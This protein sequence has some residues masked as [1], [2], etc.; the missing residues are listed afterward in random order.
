MCAQSVNGEAQNQ[1]CFVCILVHF[2]VALA[3]AAAIKYN[4]Y[5]MFYSAIKEKRSC[6]LLW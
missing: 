1:V 5:R 3:L 4:N 6:I 2:A